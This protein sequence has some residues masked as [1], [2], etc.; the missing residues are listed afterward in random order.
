MTANRGFTSRAFRFGTGIGRC[1]V[2]RGYGPVG[3]TILT[4]PAPPVFKQGGPSARIS[5]A[6]KQ[7]TPKVG[8]VSIE[9]KEE[10]EC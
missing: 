4:P 8:S 5:A 3:T 2:S 6:K 9:A 1:S 7:G 10:E